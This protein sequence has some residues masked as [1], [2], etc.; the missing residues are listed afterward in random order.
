MIIIADSGSTKTDWALCF[1]NKHRIVKTSGINPYMQSELQIIQLIKEELM[2]EIPDLD[3]GTPALHVY[4]YGAGC[5]PEKIPSVQYALALGMTLSAEQ[6]TVHSDLMAAA[7]GLLQQREGIA[8]ILGTGSNSCHYDGQ[9]ITA[10]VSPLGFILGDEGSGAVLGKKLVGNCLKHQFS[11]AICQAFEA[12][13]GLT[14][15]EIIQQ[16]YRQA[17]PNRFL[18][19]FAPFLYEHRQEPE[20]EQFLIHEFEEFVQRNILAY[21][22][23]TGAISCTGS[24]AWYF[25][26]YLEKALQNHQLSVGSIV[27]SPLEGLIQY[28]TL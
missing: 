28:H 14:T 2:P 10:N 25:R 9:A 7:H 19:S 4:F 16:V 21:R 6:I 22:P 27:K 3:R 20:I 8:C 23:F 1:G 17:F 5:T 15:A 18:A 11:P 13:Y 24:I 26:E 12:K